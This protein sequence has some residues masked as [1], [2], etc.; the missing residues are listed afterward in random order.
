VETTQ[1]AHGEAQQ[2]QQQQQQQSG[3]ALVPAHL[4]ASPTGTDTDADGASRG[5]SEPPATLLPA[6][7]L[8]PLPMEVVPTVQK[9]AV[10]AADGQ[11][12]CVSAGAQCQQ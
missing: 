11:H 2:Q 3:A 7:P 6:E 5:E 10:S 9:G 1:N 4:S 12:L 8:P